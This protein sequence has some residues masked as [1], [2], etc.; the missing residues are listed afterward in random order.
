MR[1][2]NV[3]PVVLAEREHEEILVTEILPTWTRNAVPQDQPVVIV[4]AGP[5]GSGKSRLCDLLLAVLARRGG[6]VL[7]GRDLYKKAHPQYDALM[8]EDD[9]TAGVRVRPDVLR[10]QA[11]VEAHVRRERFDAVLEAP[12][13]DLAQAIA[14]TQI[15]RTAGYRVEVVA[16]AT[17]EAEAQLSALDRYLTQVDEQGVGRSVSWGN[18][19]QCTRNL[20]L[21]LEA[22]EAERLADQVMVVR[23]GL[24][25]L[26][27]NELTAEGTSWREEEAAPEALTAEWGR[28]WTAPETWQF[29]RRLASTEQRLHPTVLAPER[30][31]AI[32][33]GLE[34]A[35]AL[36]EPVR[37]IAQPL[38]VPP[39]VD[40]HRLSAN[41][42]RW[43]FDELIVPMFL[44]TI[45]PQ[46][47]PVTL[48]V[49]GP[50]GS[51]KSHTA[52][53]LRRALRVRRPTRI[54]GGTFKSLHPDYRQL[55]QEEPRTASARIRADYRAWQ[56]MAEAHVRARRG[57]ML[58]EIA[59]DSI[60]H[61]LNS[62]RRDHRA[63][64]R[65][66]LVVI[67]ARAADSRLGTATRCAEVARMG[68]APRFTAAAAHTR[69]FGIVP[70]VVRAAEASPY[71]HCVSVI[72]RDLTALYR[73][74]RTP[75]GAWRKPARGGDVLEAEQHRPY[76]PA[77]AAH[78]LATLQRL[79]GELPQY[80]A[81]LVEIAAMA[82]PLMPAHLQPRTL[83]STITPAQ[84]PV[85]T[86]SRYRPSSSWAR[87]A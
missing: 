22:V 83:A 81:D 11:E 49:M 50:Q 63:G 56:E 67:G 34:R 40:Y 79:K 42:H 3:V 53:A 1:D 16:L 29:R 86:G 68:V 84:L 75:D 28:P 9:L 72:R 2:E 61:F 57:D 4:V 13:A 76:T 30:R 25:V 41:E 73:N 24:Y 69:T 62:A 65:V 82:W 58:V 15:W 12:I 8:R 78:L 74:E 66:E 38:T 44:G 64:R 7:I 46:D 47:D 32:A 26:Y 35:F 87:A 54:E 5:A 14:T 10:W 23:R 85:R 52:R 80:W 51:G 31:L 36:A 45:T 19:E 17:S 33:G 60:D 6:A 70:A 71:V 20:P 77:E 39:G 48:Y 21:F 55:L 27:R 59:P 37:R 18:L 43:V